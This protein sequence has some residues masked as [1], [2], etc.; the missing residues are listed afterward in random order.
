MY[1]ADVG[2]VYWEEINFIPA[3]E[4][5]T[6]GHNFGWD[7]M[8]GAHCYPPD[9]EDDCAFFGELPVAEYGHDDQGGCWITGL[10]VYRDGVYFSSDFCSGRVWGLAQDDGGTWQ[11]EELLDTELLVTGAGLGADGEIYVTACSCVFCRDY[12]PLENRAGTVW[13]I[14]PAD[15]VP[16]GAETAPLAE[17]TDEE[18][19]DEEIAEEREEEIGGEDDA[20][21]AVGGPPAG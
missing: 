16:E 9:E 7:H 10:G 12:D 4:V 3:D 13:Q 14:V 18:E 2:Q 21:P 5:T 20:R 11:F 6:G 15:E 17:G 8:E 1:I 19:E